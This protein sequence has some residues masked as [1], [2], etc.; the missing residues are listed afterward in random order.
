MLSYYSKMFYEIDSHTN[1]HNSKN[2]IKI[3]QERQPH[4]FNKHAI[5]KKYRVGQ[6]VYLNARNL[7]T[8][9]LYKKLDYKFIGLYQIIER[10]VP[11]RPTQVS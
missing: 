2:Q 10:Y 4:F 6:W 9:H 8:T 3:A 7:K 11:S 5:D 1:S